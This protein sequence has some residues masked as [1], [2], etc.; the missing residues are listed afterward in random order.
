M[1]AMKRIETGVFLPT[2]KNGF[3]S[4]VHSPP[5][6][7]SYQDLLEISLLADEIGMDYVFSMLKW[8][9]F[10]GKIEYWD[11]SFESFS[12]MAALAAATKRVDLIATVNPLLFHPAVMAKMAA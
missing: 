8:R 5:Y 9:G 3:V 6:H 2:G 4:S 1:K 10:G 12:L 7:P 11:A